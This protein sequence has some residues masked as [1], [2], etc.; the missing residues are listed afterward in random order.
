M[1]KARRYVLAAPALYPGQTSLA[2][3]SA[4]ASWPDAIR[5]CPPDVLERYAYACGG[6]K[7]SKKGGKLTGKKRTAGE[8][9]D[10]DD[11]SRPYLRR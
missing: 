3:G 11:D 10:G 8:Q 4:A 1:T 5:S 7:P 9:T 2:G 6:V